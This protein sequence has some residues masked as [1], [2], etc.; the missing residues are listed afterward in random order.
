MHKLTKRLPIIALL[1]LTVFTTLAQN[2]TNSPYS[3]LGF[4]DFEPMGFGRNAGMG[5]TGIALQSNYNLNNTN[6][7]TLA[8]LDSLSSIFE[9]GVHGSY[10]NLA[11]S[12]Q[13]SNR[14]NA[15]VSYLAIGLCINSKWGMSFGVVPY[16]SV[17]YNIEYQDQIDGSLDEFTM[18]MKGTGGLSSIYWANGYQLTKNLSVGLNTAFLFGPK[19]EELQFVFDDNK[20]YDISH[21]V[22]NTYFGWKFDFGAQYNVQLNNKNNLVLGA[23]FNAPGSLN[24]K[25]KTTIINSI[26]DLNVSDT[27]QFEVEEKE[28][29]YF[30]TNFGLGISYNYNHK[31]TLAL[32]YKLDNWSKTKVDDSN[33]DLINN[34]TFNT[35]IEFSPAST[36]FTNATTYRAGFKYQSGYFKID[37]SELK[38]Y[39]V[40]AGVGF[41]VRS[42][43]I[44]V[45]TEYGWRGTTKHSLIAEKYA[46]IGINLS[47]RDVW[48][49]K[50]TYK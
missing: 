20:S 26:P 33:A 10:T 9:F 31:L 36:Q 19:T 27:I 22:S 40:T 35:G 37:E 12:S 15:N 24:N 49:Q 43:Y 44:N 5:G 17:G 28:K 32:D 13:Q 50:R 2:N 6:P 4:G 8:N 47:L 46:K 18:I 16:S 45:Y 48:F 11:N 1:I 30:P 14:W 29:I 25:T 23:T 41:P 34:H 7:A 38:S 39:S 21:K 3:K 42:S